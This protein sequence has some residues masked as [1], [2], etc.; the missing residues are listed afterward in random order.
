VCNCRTQRAVLSSDHP[1]RQRHHVVPPLLALVASARGTK[2]ENSIRLWLLDV[3]AYR[4]A[5]G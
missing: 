2:V 3:A 5:I 1:K 4:V